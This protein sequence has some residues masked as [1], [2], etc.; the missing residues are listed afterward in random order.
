[1]VLAALVLPA[2]PLYG[3]APAPDPAQGTPPG[4]TEGVS[5]ETAQD[6]DLQSLDTSGV[7][8]MLD[9]I[10][11]Q[12]GDYAPPLRLDDFL[13]FFR[14]RDLGYSFTRLGQGLLSYL[15][16]EVLANS[17]LLGRLVVLAV[18]AALLQN[19]QSAFERESVGKFAYYVVYLVLVVLALGG[20]GVAMTAARDAIKD[21]TTF[22]WALLPV[23]IAL[24]AGTGAV[25]LA[26]L[27]HPA[28]I[29]TINLVSL[30]AREVVFPLL[31]FAAVIEIVGSLSDSFK[32]SNLAGFL[33]QASLT[34]LGGM[35]S[36]F[37]GVAIIQG[38][39]GSVADGITLR[40][41]KFMAASFVPVIGKMFGDA[42]ELVIG[43]SVAL[44]SAVG[45]LGAT[46]ILVI[47]AFP[48][49]KV[50][51][52]IIA[53]RLAAVIVQPVG[54]GRIVDCLNGIASAL[55]LVFLAVATV[56]LMFFIGTTMIVLA[57]NA[58]VM[59]R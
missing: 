58:A 1:M 44:K 5:P 50:V 55:N 13:N 33:R 59:M 18:L 52:V 48:L 26:G 16:H 23:L 41:A 42:A 10:N 30:A 21:L 11:R 15:F 17:R 45:L 27:F 56:A 7:R 54:A 22:M 28:M 51:A 20:F 14:Q 43:S 35:F 8:Q 31:F 38:A 46:A 32:I 2:R 24:L 9:E 57:G 6:Q 3:S 39:A 29:A 49:M 25:T 4:G 34:I 40:T 12:V 47:A 53:Y 36:L 19:L 37:L